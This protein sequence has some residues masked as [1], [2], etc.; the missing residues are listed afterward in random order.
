MATPLRSTLS[1]SLAGAT[2]DNAMSNRSPENKFFIYKSPRV[3]DLKPY[4]AMRL[5][6]TPE[7]TQNRK[8][9]ITVTFLATTHR[10]ENTIVLKWRWAYRAESLELRSGRTAGEHYER[11]WLANSDFFSAIR[12]IR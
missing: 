9:G 1:S 2:V 5:A 3:C 8:Q 11:D 10:M 7:V 12:S 4:T 6:K